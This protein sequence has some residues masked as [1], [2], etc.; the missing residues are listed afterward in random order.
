MNA[1]AEPRPKPRGQYDRCPGCGDWKIT[2]AT[3]CRSC[4]TKTRGEN[5]YGWKGNA[6]KPNAKRAR[7]QKQVPLGLCEKCGARATDRYRRDGSADN[8]A[9]ENIG[10]MCRRC[11]MEY[12]GRMESLI[13]QASRAAMSQQRRGIDKTCPQCGAQFYV[14]PTQALRRKFC[15]RRCHGLSMKITPEEKTRRRAN[16]HVRGWNVKEKGE[17]ECRNC[18]SRDRLHLHHAIPRSK[19]RAGRDDLR[20]GVTLCF[21]CHMGWHHHRVTLYR[22][23]FSAVEWVFM[24]TAVLTGQRVEAWLDTRYPVRPL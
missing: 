22:D 13:A 19:W 8:D 9:L 16:R 5:N 10:Q 1:Q 11:L 18:G 21:D 24:S 15:S 3:A 4:S 14:K 2:K 17:R 7:I 12:D 6:A 20:N 23:I